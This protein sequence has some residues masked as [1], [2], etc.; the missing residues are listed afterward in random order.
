MIKTKRTP[1]FSKDLKIGANGEE[2]FHKRFQ[3]ALIK[4]DGLKADFTVSNK[5]GSG[6]ELKTDTYDSPNFFIERYS[7]LWKQTPG[8]PF[9]AIK[10]SKYFAYYFI[11]KN[12]YYLFDLELL[13]PALEEYISNKNPRKVDV[14][15]KGYTTGG[16]V[17]PIN[18]LKALAVCYKDLNG[19][20]NITPT[21]GYIPCGCQKCTK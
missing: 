21:E 5:D 20:D 13:V 18:D 16:Y 14:K 10:H 17:I 12:T 8:G 9:Q 6:L 1:N 11:N 3:V 7:D 2:Q 4:Q 15:N 19:L